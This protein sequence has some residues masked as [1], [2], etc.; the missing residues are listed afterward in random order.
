MEVGTELHARIDSWEGLSRWE[1]S[2]LGKDL[3]RLG[4]SYSEIMELIPVKKSTL[5]TWC[6]E[7]R[8]NDEQL[9]HILERT[10]S[11]LGIPRDTNWKRRLQ[12]SEI[13]HDAVAEAAGLISD[14]LWVAGTALYWAEGYKTGSSLGMANADPAALKLFMAWCRA[15]HDTQARFR[16]RLNIHAD[17]DEY[18]ARIW[19]AKALNLGMEDFT[20]S[21]VKPDGTGHRK[22]HLAWGVCAVRMRRSANAFHRTHAWVEFLASHVDN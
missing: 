9:R 16:A 6:R 21:F 7:V 10:G 1:R 8:L 14:P 5:A 20:K 2:E 15:Y 17:N 3:R 22:N 13:R 18:G 12:I 19:W 4:L 11:R